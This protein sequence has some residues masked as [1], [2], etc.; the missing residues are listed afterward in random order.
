MS[1][2]KLIR[3]AAG[4]ELVAVTVDGELVTTAQN[5]ETD[6]WVGALLKKLGHAYQEVKGDPYA[7]DEAAR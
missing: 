7:L 3:C 5:Y 4:N 6:V 2:V 1:D